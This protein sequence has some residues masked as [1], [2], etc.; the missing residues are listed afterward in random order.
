MKKLFNRQEAIEL[1]RKGDKQAVLEYD[2]TA[3][4]KT[5]YSA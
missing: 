2:L 3:E 1:L 4:H 5:L